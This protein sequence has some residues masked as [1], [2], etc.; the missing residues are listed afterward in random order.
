MIHLSVI[1]RRCRHWIR[2]LLRLPQGRQA[3]GRRQGNKPPI[4]GSAPESAEPSRPQPAV[5][6][7]T[8]EQLSP[9]VGIAPYVVPTTGEVAGLPSSNAM[10]VG[11]VTF[12]PPTG[13]QVTKSGQ[14]GVFLKAATRETKAALLIVEVPFSGDFRS[15]F[16]SVLTAR[17]PV[18]GLELKNPH[19]GVTSAGSPMIQIH[20]RGTLRGTRQR[21]HVYAVGVA[22]ENKM[23]LAMLMSGDWGG[24]YI[25][26]EK[27]F[28]KL[29]SHWRLS[30]EK[31][32]AWDPL[33]PPP[34]TGARAGLFFGA[35][36]QN[37]I[38]PLGGLDLLSIREYIVL[39]PTGQVFNGLPEGGHILDMDF[40]AEC[41]RHPHSCG[42]YRIAGNR[43]DF[44]WR[45]EY[46]MVTRDTSEFAGGA[47]GKSTIASF[48]GTH[49]SE[50]LPVQNL[51]LTGRY[52]ST[53]A[54]VGSNAFQSTSVVS[55]TYISFFPDGT[56]SKSG[57]A[58]GS[59]TNTS[60]AGTVSNR[61]A[62]QTGRYT[63]NGYA[64]TLS[65][66]N[67]APQETFTTVFEENSASPK[68]VF[69]D[70]KAFLRDKRQ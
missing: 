60:A 49:L 16:N 31:G 29:V 18:S 30:G 62:A 12:V 66:S 50:T 1:V 59:F 48:N 9:T 58:A 15:A 22:M 45:G 51:R 27:A 11:S 4:A 33:R 38:N 20:D 36:L 46:G 25:G 14:D 41:T 19:Q 13:W 47:P 3:V 44:T 26:F 35:R 23:V 37:Q 2:L 54:Q 17:C 56:Y 39:L 28:E 57:F 61:K 24:D 70:D 8:G 6:E 69:I 32:P 67:G 34:P 43:I 42:T 63:M 55:E 52:T 65:P 64:L 68:A 21:E 5:P 10:T 7:T 53:F 40:T